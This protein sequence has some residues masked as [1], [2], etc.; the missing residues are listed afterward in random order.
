MSISFRTVLKWFWRYAKPYQWAFYACM[1]STTAIYVLATIA[2][3]FYKR[4]LDGIATSD[5]STE[6]VAAM[7]VTVGMIGLVI[8][9]RWIF[10]R[11]TGYL[12]VFFESRVL[13]AMDEGMFRQLMYHSYAFFANNFAGTLT[14][15]VKRFSDAFERLTDSFLFNILPLAITTIGAVVVL[16]MRDWRLSAGF[17]ASV[18]VILV[19]NIA[20]ARWRLKFDVARSEKDSAVSGSLTD[21]FANIVNV[22]A[23]A[24]QR[25]EEDRFHV[26]RGELLFAQKKSW[27]LYETSAAVQA[28]VMLLVE[29]GIV[30]TAVKLWQRGILTVGDFVLI[31]AYL[32]SVFDQLRGIGNIMRRIFESVADAKE[33]V[34]I[35]EQM[36]DVR[37][38]PRAKSIVVKKG[39]IDFQEVTFNYHKTRKTIDRLSL[40][41]ASGERVAFIGPS[42][43]GK[44]TFVKL[45]LR[46]YDA[47]S[48]HILID[49]QDIRRVTQESL[50]AQIAF[51]SQDPILFHRT[52]RENIQYARLDATQEE[53][54]HAAKLAHCHEFI[55]NLPEGYDTYVG[56]RGIKLSGGERQR[57]AIARA[58]LKDA[59][60]LVLD[61]ATSSLDSE[62]EF[63]IQD[64]LQ[65]L[66]KGRTTIAI[67]HRLS[68]IMAMDRILVLDG[69]KIVDQGTHD[70]L[71]KRGGLYQ[72]LWNI[73]AG[74]FLTEGEV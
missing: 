66:M 36:P 7:L 73:Q 4:L 11:I 40:R 41:I 3:L 43:A 71:L 31:Q 2:P 42:G 55:V 33:L 18:M 26:I 49:G 64:A 39:T 72:K 38:I 67:A 68:T 52:I 65:V 50:R 59:P 58:I 5:R 37:D 48:G 1:L 32:I 17:F 74:G 10:Y 62:S 16:F 35:V 63:L 13:N 60:I 29:I 53:V 51:V 27:N 12:I 46:F 34:E 19:G 61:E 21:A 6:A 9:S 70:E 15:R 44:S 30:F 47:D 69:G 56:E 25:F 20:F 23:F 24:R 8:G 22:K 28:F 45:L 57:V 54:E 14:R